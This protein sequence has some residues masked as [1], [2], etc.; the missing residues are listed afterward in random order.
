MCAEESEA[1]FLADFRPVRDRIQIHHER[2]LADEIAG[3]SSEDQLKELTGQFAQRADGI[4]DRQ[5][6]TRSKPT[7]LSGSFIMPRLGTVDE[8]TL[9]EASNPSVGRVEGWQGR[10]S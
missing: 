7:V 5:P 8:P 9:G 4:E 3:D 1:E 6:K 10:F 2:L